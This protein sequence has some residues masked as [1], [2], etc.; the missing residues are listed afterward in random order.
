MVDS[1]MYYTYISDVYISHVYKT[2]LLLLPV[3]NYFLG[4]LEIAASSCGNQNRK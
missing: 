2:K 4:N 1:L 3:V